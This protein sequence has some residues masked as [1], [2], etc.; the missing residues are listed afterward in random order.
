MHAAHCRNILNMVPEAHDQRASQQVTVTSNSHAFKAITFDYNLFEYFST[1]PS[2][3]TTI[4]VT[5]TQQY[6][7]SP[8][9]THSIS[10]GCAQKA[11]ITIP[12]STAELNETRA[13]ISA[14]KTPISESQALVH[15]SP[16]PNQ[17]SDPFSGLQ[18]CCWGTLDQ[19]SWSVPSK[20]GTTNVRDCQLKETRRCLVCCSEPPLSHSFCPLPPPRKRF[21]KTHIRLFNTRKKFSSHKQVGRHISRLV[22]CQL[23]GQGL[24]QT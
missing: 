14:G 18:Y 16:Y 23:K 22:E 12:P 11:F 7:V 2:Y 6:R 20:E 4:E 5:E 21:S 8:Y 9:K 3:F 15:S 13:E 17:S 1:I 10:S 24:L 19:W